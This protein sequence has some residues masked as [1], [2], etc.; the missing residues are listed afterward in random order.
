MRMC[1]MHEN[2]MKSELQYNKKGGSAKKI[3]K[4][5]HPVQYHQVKFNCLSFRN[6]TQLSILVALGLIL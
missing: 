6:A 1:N 3:E 5:Y 2:F 4:F